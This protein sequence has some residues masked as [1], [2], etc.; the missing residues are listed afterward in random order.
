MAITIGNQAAAPGVIEEFFQ[1]DYSANDGC[2]RIRNIAG[3]G[4][5]RF[6]LRVPD[7][8]Q[9]VL[10]VEAIGWPQAGASGAGKDIDLTSEYGGK[11]ELKNLH[12]ETDTTSTYTL[13]AIDT[14]F[15]LDL[16]PVLSQLAAGDGA[17]IQIDQN[18]IG[19]IVH[20]LGIR[21]RYSLP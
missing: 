16:T 14:V 12:A 13:P 8:A 18:G 1:A 5:F 9:A 15:G 3:T 21:L 6:N 4:V 17:G 11:G 10:A 20:W 19:G 7:N 2:Y